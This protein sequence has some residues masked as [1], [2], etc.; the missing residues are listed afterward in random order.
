MKQV[1]IVVFVPLTHTDIIREAMND[2]G[3]GILGNYNYCSL[4]SIT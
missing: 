2:A 4:I 1:K 3:A